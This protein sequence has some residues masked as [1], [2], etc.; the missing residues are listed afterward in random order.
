MHTNYCLLAIR[1]QE[2]KCF[3]REPLTDWPLVNTHLS[4]GI[5]AHVDFDVDLFSKRA[6]DLTWK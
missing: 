5:C 6:A 3:P 4:S 1:V 2:I